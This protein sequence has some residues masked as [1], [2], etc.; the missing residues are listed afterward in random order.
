MVRF[1]LKNTHMKNVPGSAA[2]SANPVVSTRG[3][4]WVESGPST[5]FSRPPT[6]PWTCTAN[7][8]LCCLQNVLHTVLAILK[9]NVDI[10]YCLAH[11]S[12]L[13]MSANTDI[14]YVP[15]LWGVCRLTTWWNYGWNHASWMFGSQDISG[16]VCGQKSKRLLNP[17]ASLPRLNAT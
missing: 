12:R 11:V 2:Y 17:N 5:H 6:A 15:V 14:I 8:V 4:V 9:K 13:S 10:S 16:I 3:S 1:T 7:G